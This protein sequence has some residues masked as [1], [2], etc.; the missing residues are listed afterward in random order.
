MLALA[1]KLDARLAL[2]ALNS[3]VKQ[4]ASLSK[5]FQQIKPEMR[6][7]QREH[8][9]AKEG[10]DSKWPPR[11]ASTMAKLRANGKRARRPLGKLLTAVRYTARKGGVIGQSTIKWSG[12][13]MEGGVVGRGSVIKPRPF[14]WISDKL[15]ERAAAILRGHMLEGWPAIAKPERR[16]GKR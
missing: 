3:V 2:W 8:A 6:A 11:A 13:H 10:P 12:V 15:R 7:D 5:A 14:L 1:G 9:K 16:R 4:G